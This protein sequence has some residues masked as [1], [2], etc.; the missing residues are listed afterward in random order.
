MNP[1]LCH[2][3]TAN[4]HDLEDC[5]LVI[6]IGHVV[7]SIQYRFREHSGSVVECL[8]RDEGVAGSSLTRVTALCP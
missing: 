2:V 5:C 8:T 1:R 4:C 6:K 3:L 7:Y